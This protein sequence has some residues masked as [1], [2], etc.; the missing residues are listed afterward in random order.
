MCFL[1]QALATSAARS[2]HV[3]TDIVTLLCLRNAKSGGLSSWSSSISVHNEILK[4]APHLAE[5]LAGPH[6]YYDRKG[7]VSRVGV[8][9]Y[10]H[11][12]C[13]FQCHSMEMF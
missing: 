8:L 10:L 12:V 5:A 3:H 11:N 4:R 7:E 9:L 6:W 2:L 13:P 1:C